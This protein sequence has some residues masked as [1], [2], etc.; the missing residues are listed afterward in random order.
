MK[1]LERLKLVN[2]PT[3]DKHEPNNLDHG[4]VPLCDHGILLCFPYNAAS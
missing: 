1:Y 2:L 4:H 3:G